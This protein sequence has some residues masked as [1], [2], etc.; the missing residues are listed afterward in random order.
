MPRSHMRE[1]ILIC[2]CS[3]WSSP[4]CGN[5]PPHLAA[6]QCLV[7]QLP[8]QHVSLRIPLQVPTNGATTPDGKV[9]YPLRFPIQAQAR[10]A[11]PPK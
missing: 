2:N 6:V 3:C 5:G 7:D 11:G 8:F 4:T 10:K 9:I 1:R